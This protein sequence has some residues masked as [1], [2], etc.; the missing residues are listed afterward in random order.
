VDNNEYHVGRSQPHHSSPPGP[1]G[2]QYTA[3]WRSVRPSG[4]VAAPSGA[5]DEGRRWADGDG[6]DS[7][8]S[9]L[10]IGGKWAWLTISDG[11]LVAQNA[12]K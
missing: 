9:P 11:T 5:G 10:D 7:G 3:R 6:G 2:C 8:P 4:R 1:I 12:C